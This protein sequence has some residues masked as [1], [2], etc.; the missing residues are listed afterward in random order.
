MLNISDD[1]FQ[2]FLLFK[3]LMQLVSV[4]L[5]YVLSMFM[6]FLGKND[7]AVT[8]RGGAWEREREGRRE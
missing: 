1:V 6:S 4:Y 2:L 8:I 3:P 7:L 5:T